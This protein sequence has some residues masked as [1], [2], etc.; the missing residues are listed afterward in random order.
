M[1][2]LSG[3]GE[4][5]DNPEFFDPAVPTLSIIDDPAQTEA[6]DL[7]YN[8]LFKQWIHHKNVSILLFMQNFYKQEKSMHDVHLNA[9]YLI[10]YK[11]CHDVN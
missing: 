4:I 6:D 7:R 5:L 11:N 1:E 9:Q 3:Q 10:L 2:F 8:K